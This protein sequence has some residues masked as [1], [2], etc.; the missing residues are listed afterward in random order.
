MSV[1]WDGYDGSAYEIFL[2]DGT[3]TTQLTNNSYD[4]RQPQIYGSSVVWDGIDGS[5]CEVFLATPAAAVPEPGTLALLAATL[6][7]LV[8]WRRR[9]AG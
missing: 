8:R 6:L 4:D 7:P 3:S 2:Y 1:V 9:R 5:D